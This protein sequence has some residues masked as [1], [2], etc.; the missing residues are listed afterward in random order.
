MACV[1]VVSVDVVNVATPPLTG[2]VPRTVDP[3]L[4]VIVPVAAV[5]TD[6]VNVTD[7]AADEGFAE[8]VNVTIGGAGVTVTVVAGDVAGL[9]FASPGVLAVIGSLPTGRLFTVIVATPPTTGAVPM[10]VVPLE[11][12]TGPETPLG[13]VSVIV[14]VP[15]Y[16]SVGAETTGGGSEGVALFTICVSGA[17]VAAL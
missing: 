8:D 2:A 10:T 15:P 17:D 5:G 6:A 13:T 1:P 4:N 9:L 16:G 14:S 3:S 12:V 7:W 11:K